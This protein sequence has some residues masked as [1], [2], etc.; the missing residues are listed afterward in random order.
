ME[1]LIDAAA[2]GDRRDDPGLRIVDT[3][4]YLGEPDRGPAAYRAGHI[5]GAL[6]LDLDRDLSAPTG[7]GRHP[8]P[9]PDAFA[10]RLGSLGIG[11]GHDVVAYDDRGG[12]VAA[13]L[14]WMLRHL[15]HDEVAVLD[16]G[17]PA[18]EA[19][20]LPLSTAEP[21][22]P[23]ATFTPR[24]RPGGTLDRDEVAAGLDDLVL[25]DARSVERY[26]GDEDPVDPV[27]GHIPTAISAPCTDNLGPDQRFLPAAAL[28][29]RYRRLGATE[30]E[31]VVAY[32]GSGV[33][34]CHDLLAMELA[35]LGGARLYPGSWSDWSAHGGAVAIGE[36]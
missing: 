19:A 26:R 1:P 23:A 16:G 22:W 33:T 20:G 14:W 17:L 2:L 3:R 27:A 32:C 5:P 35:G 4:W 11:D 7:P 30:P 12:V 9:D 21:D 24:L 13:R 36:T 15:G 8:L 10:A 31:R 18:W 29:E 28:A 6:Y 25:L 34:A